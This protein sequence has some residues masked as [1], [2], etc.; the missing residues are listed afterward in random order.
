[1]KDIYV[2]FLLQD[3]LQASTSDQYFEQKFGIEFKPMV[4]NILLDAEENE[5]KKS[6]IIYRS[7]NPGYETNSNLIVGEG[8]T[9]L[10]DLM[11]VNFNGFSLFAG[12]D[13]GECLE[14][15]SSLHAHR[16]S[17]SSLMKF[18]GG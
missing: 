2:D 12:N 7:G 16:G 10:Q 3:E 1:M 4:S 9:A 8:L 6:E 13:S 18:G 15:L 14:S 17:P 11:A 5:P